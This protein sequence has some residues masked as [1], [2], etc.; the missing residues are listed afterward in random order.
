MN[1]KRVLTSAFSNLYTDQ[2][3]EK[4]CQTLFQNGYCVELIGNDWKG[5]EEMQRPY[6]FSRINLR[7]KTLKT[8]YFEF[9]WKLYHELKKK[10]DEN[11]I[12][13]ANDLDAL[14]PNY[15]LSKTL[16]IPL[17]FDSHEIFSEMP[18]VQGKISQKIWRYLQGK[19]IPNIQFMITAS[20][21]YAQWFQNQYHINP[22][23]VQNAPKRI[24]LPIEIPENSPKIILYQGALNPFRG[25]DKAILAM[26]HLDNVIFK[27]A[28]DGPRKKEFEDLVLS[29][30][31]QDKVQ[32]LGK[33]LPEDLRK[34]T[35]TVDVGM[36][37][38]ENAGESYQYALPNKVLDCIQARV[39]LILSELPE[40]QN[41]KN[42]F[43]IGEII[44]D[45]QPENIAKAI[46]M[47][48]EKGR[49][50]YQK[51]LNKASQAFCW[52]NEEVKLLQVFEETSQSV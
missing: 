25:I 11:T 19:I 18:A 13:Y 4:V 38:E 47:V 33:L 3:I 32:F 7:S 28:G 21:S 1:R 36:S 16:N 41:I 37:I 2:R 17:V 31:L 34:I 27:I 9:N 12:L 44:K 22:V 48:L 43:D 30:K 39:P 26:H 45:H 46:K 49:G 50:N 15:I 20:E 35:L 8:A 52:E 24:N 40:M 29:E 14:L 23:V 51:E 6:S 42:L 5:A 10:A